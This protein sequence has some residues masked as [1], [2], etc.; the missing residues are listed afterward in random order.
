MSSSNQHPT[1]KMALRGARMTLVDET[2]EARRLDTQRLKKILGQPTL[3]GARYLYKEE[4]T[5]HLVHTMIVST[6]YVP[7]VTEYDW[8]TW[9]RLLRLRM[10]ITFRSAT[11]LPPEGT[12]EPW[13]RLADPR[14]KKALKEDGDVQA[15][16]LAWLVR[17]AMA[18]YA[19]GECQPVG[20]EPSRIKDDTRAWRASDDMILNYA[21]EFL[22]PAEGYAVV[23]S[24]LFAHF[25]AW[26]ESNGH[27][28][29]SARTFVSRF[30]EHEVIKGMK[31][32]SQ[33]IRRSTE[34]EISHPPDAWGKGSEALPGQF[35]A[36]KK[37]R[38]RSCAQD[39]DEDLFAD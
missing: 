14:L 27:K 4:M 11:T 19:A 6:N 5:V 10:P 23:A 18:W 13:E 36:Y 1:E 3:A 39:L 25:T 16:C 26:A 38:F 7:A 24:E 32:V 9:R 31:I 29:W 15:A 17:G 33:R 21:E 8:G 37:V 30:T 20:D 22:E 12:R 34:I 35:A 2:P 28:P